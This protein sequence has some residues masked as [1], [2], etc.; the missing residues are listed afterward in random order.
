METDVTCASGRREICPPAT[1]GEL[2]RPT[3]SRANEGKSVGLLRSRRR[4]AGGMT[5]GSGCCAGIALRSSC[6]ERKQ[7]V[8]LNFC[9][10]STGSMVYPLNDI[11]AVAVWAAGGFDEGFGDYV[12]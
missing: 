3:R 10:I 9:Q 6:C 12:N 7:E 5:V 2:R 8:G 1:A 11:G 4:R